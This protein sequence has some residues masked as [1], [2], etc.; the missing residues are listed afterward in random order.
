MV[1]PTMKVPFTC[2][3]QLCSML[4]VGGAKGNGKGQ[5]LHSVLEMLLFEG[6]KV[7]RVGKLMNHPVTV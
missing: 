6:T 2:A 1:V 3:V 4:R 7:M 5:M